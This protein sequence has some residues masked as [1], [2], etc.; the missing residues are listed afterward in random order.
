MA[1]VSKSEVFLKSALA[2]L[3]HE[4]VGYFGYMMHDTISTALNEQIGLEGQSSHTYL[5]MAVWAET[6]G[7]DGVAAFL[8]AHSE[9]ERQ[10]MLKLMRFVNERGAVA[11]VPSVHAGATEYTGLKEVFE[12]ILAHE[13]KV[14]ECINNVVDLCL[15]AKDYTTHNIN[16]WYVSEHIYEYAMARKILDKLALAGDDH[17]ALYLFDRDIVTFGA[18]EGE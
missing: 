3:K 13:T 4:D 15:Q 11:N 10:H 14:T 8:Y 2:R 17:G 16:Q 6:Q 9:E 18:S 1:S 5:T 12:S 7:F